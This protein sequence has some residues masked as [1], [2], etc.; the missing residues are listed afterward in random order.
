M[1]ART[2]RIRRGGID[3]GL[4]SARIEA[5][6]IAMNAYI[7]PVAVL[8]LR[9]VAGGAARPLVVPGERLEECQIVGR[10]ESQDAVNVHSSIPGTVRAIKTIV[11]ADGSASEAVIVDLGGS[12]SRLGRK[13]EFYPWRGLPIHSLVHTLVEKGVTL[14]ERGGR[15]LGLV[16]NQAAKAKPEALIVDCID[17]EHF[18]AA[19]R[20]CLKSNPAEL[21]EAI[22]ISVR[23]LGSCRILVC[24]EAPD[25][26]SIAAFGSELDKRE[27]KWKA[28]PVAYRYPTTHPDILRPLVAKAAG[29][30]A[31]RE[32]FDR[33]PILYPTVLRSV[34]DAVALNKAAVEQI[35]SVSG[36][37]I[38]RSR[39]LKVRLGMRIGDLIA[40]CGGFKVP[41]AR[42]VMG[43]ALTGIAVTD[44][45]APIMKT[46]PSILALSENEI[47]AA[48]KRPCIHCGRCIEA[49][50]ARLDPGVLVKLIDRDR[51]AE[52]RSEGLEKCILCG[53]CGHAC[54][55]RLGLS[56]SIA[57]AM[58]DGNEG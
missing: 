41:P 27:I 19:E 21:A 17:A 42:I 29:L 15:P 13:Q 18:Q 20:V 33:W 3:L 44:L 6:E 16:L 2:I 10:A 22:E 12:F 37:A 25:P 26:R 55:A 51:R 39:T 14:R 50:P 38:K 34:Y 45:N 40:E 7:P 47:K 54:P 57:A 5:D 9:Q 43:G 11:L 49:C 28:I 23:I 31:K 58:A 32:A 53:A 8:S 24:Y 36:G 48:K 56:K 1:T 4:N 35:V 46:T 52:A 30:N